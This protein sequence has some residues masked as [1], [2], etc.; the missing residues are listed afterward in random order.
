MRKV[1]SA[2]FLVTL[3]SVLTSGCIK[4]TTACNPKSPASEQNAMLSFINANNINA[5][6][7]SSGLFYEVLVP[8]SGNTAVNNSIVTVNYIGRLL[9]GTVFDQSTSPVAFQLSGLIEGWKIGIPL[10]QEG[11]KIR[12]IVPSSMAYGCQGNGPIPPDS[13]LDFEIDLI[14]VQ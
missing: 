3:V 11:G 1:I 8:G 14:D 12:L 7:H 10:I 4:D 2:F 13:I 6:S 5:V 9:D